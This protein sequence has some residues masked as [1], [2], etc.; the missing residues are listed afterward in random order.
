MMIIKTFLLFF[1]LCSMKNN[2]QLGISKDLS[3]KPDPRVLL[4]V[5]QDNAA[6][7]LPRGMT[8]ILPLSN[9]GTTGQGTQASIIF[10][11]E[12]GSIVQNDGARWNISDSIVVRLKNNKMARF[13][14]TG[15]VTS[16]C[17]TCGLACALT[18]K[19]C[20]SEDINFTDSNPSFNEI[21]SSV[22]LAAPSSNII[23]INSKGL[24]RVSFRGGIIG[25]STPLCLGVVINLQSRINL[26]VSSTV[27][28]TWKPINKTVSNST[29]GVLTMSMMAP[30]SIDVGQSLA[31]TYV[32]VF[33][34]GDKLRFRLDGSQNIGSGAC[35]GLLGGNNMFFSMDKTGNA[36]TEV[37]VEK[38]NMQ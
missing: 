20:S 38:I 26:E 11:K 34:I 30:G 25:I 3:F 36:L 1:I 27:D 10:N 8:S 32:G 22:S 23:T 6:I 13:V 37:I 14:R 16:T 9:M 21:T 17:G 2:A 19:N 12:T 5:K 24:Y 31:F 4:H 33:N 29:A 7:R 18:V 28:T 15:A 35:S